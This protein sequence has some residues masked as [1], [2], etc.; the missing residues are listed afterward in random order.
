M[1]RMRARGLITLSGALIASVLAPSSARAQS[2]GTTQRALPN[3]LLL[4]DNSGSMERMTDGSLPSDNPANACNPGVQSNPN[5]W[6]VLLQALAGNLQ[7]YYSCGKM[8]RANNGALVNEYRIGTQKPYDTDYFMPYHRPLAGGTAQT[9]CAMGPWRLPGGGGIGVGPLNQ[10][11]T[12]PA[13]LTADAFPNDALRKLRWS[14]IQANYPGTGGGSAIPVSTTNSCDFIM[15]DDGQLDAARDY[16]RFALMT[17]DSDVDPGIGVGQLSPVTTT[18]NA[19]P[20]LGQW[21][22]IRSTPFPYGSAGNVAMGRPVGCATNSP[23]EVGARNW[24]APPWEGRLVPFND[25]FAQLTDIERTNEQIQQVLVASRPYGATPIDGMLDDARDYLWEN[26]KGPEKADP[27]VTGG[28]RDQYIILLTD[29]APNLNMRTSCEGPTG[30]CPYPGSTP[31]GSGQSIAWDIAKTLYTGTGHHSVPVFVIGFSVNGTNSPTG[32]G[33]PAGFQTAP[34]NSCSNWFYSTAPGGFGGSSSAMSTYCRTTPPA[35]GTT[36]DAC[37]QLNEIAYFGSNGTAP[38][39]FAESQ[40]D[41]VAAFG[42]VLANITKTASTRTVPAYSSIATSTS[43]SGTRNITA[44]YTAA[45]VPNPRKPWS[46]QIDRTRQVCVSGAPQPQTFDPAQGDAFDQNVARQSFDGQ[47]RFITVKADYTNGTAIDSSRSIRPFVTTPTDGLDAYKGTE[48]GVLNND[49]APLPPEALGIDDSTCKRS[50][51][52]SGDVIPKLNKDECNKVIWGFTAAASTV[53]TYQGYNKWNVRCPSFGASKCAINAATTCSQDSDCAAV[54]PGDVCVPEC[55]A[56]GA[57]F[58]S[59]PAAVSPPMSLSRDEGYRSFAQGRAT[60]PH[61]LFVATTDGVL[62][63]F[64]SL[65]EAPI[66]SRHELWSFVPPAVLTRLASNYP[67]GQQILLDGSPIV[68]DVVWDR[69]RTDLYGANAGK[70]WHTTLVAGMG[71]N[72]PGYYALNVSDVAC[73]GTDCSTN[74]DPPA[75]ASLS[76]V[77]FSDTYSGS[78]KR[79]PHFLWQLT[80]APSVTGETLPASRTSVSDHKSFVSLFGKQTGTPAV[81]T[82]FFDP[83]DGAGAR[84]IGVAI[85]PGGTDGPPD[86]TGTCARALGTTHSASTY[87]DLSDHAYPPRNSVRQ[88]GTSCAA[89]VGGRSITVVRLDTGEI[90]RHFARFSDAPKSLKDQSKVVDSPFD[91]PMVGLPIVYPSDVGTITQKVFIG[92]ADGTMWRVD[93]SNPN[94]SQWKANLFQDLFSPAFGGT[95]SAS[96]GRP[97]AV[98]PV[99]SLDQTGNLVLN[100][101]TGDQEN[102]VATNDYNMVLSIVEG[103]PTLGLG[104]TVQASVKW[105]TRLNNGERV[106]GPMAVFDGTLY[107]ATY[108][109]E[110]IN[111]VCGEKSKQYVWGV[112]YVVPQDPSSLGSG[113][114]YKYPP[115]PFT[116]KA[117]MTDPVNPSLIPGVA[118][119]QSLNCVDTSGAVSTDFFGMTHYGVNSQTGTNYSLDIPVAKPSAANPRNVQVLTVALP[120]PRTPTIIDSWALVVD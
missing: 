36:A 44:S 18:I 30:Q 85:L 108:V 118:V 41:L 43:T 60:R 11:S 10:T 35:V 106:T 65:K 14:D 40:R 82:L 70:E 91:S 7:P 15:A 22:Y 58:R 69:V 113:G 94:P 115:T 104:N 9:A 26:A 77:S 120:R 111:N 96:A 25:A 101:A 52:L 50:R 4:V 117:D 16:V 98:P 99:A 1:R 74:Y 38:P 46:G 6:G 112:D 21:S 100:V 86:K 33:F 57:I 2:A 68:K 24:G 28:C 62:H 97:V 47:R 89:P 71:S 54:T 53:P 51:D 55:S 116:Q 63:A 107:F 81:T 78:V 20:F 17:F 102:L 42:R 114:K 79:G 76:D 66:T 105:F 34:D 29:G 87:P 83:G 92:D 64:N 56:L 12:D 5:R 110:A 3:V 23:F 27:Y 49:T 95:G 75:Y 45:F 67:T 32:D 8:D 61:A 80:D 72:G 13:G 88:W 103:R 19:S 119:K 73:N 109:P 37:C 84:E 31:T 39:F 90:I 59:S 93:L 48:L